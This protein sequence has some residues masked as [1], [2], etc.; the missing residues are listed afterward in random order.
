MKRKLETVKEEEEEEVEK[1]K[2][3]G[4]VKVMPPVK[5]TKSQKSARIERLLESFRMERA[6]KGDFEEFW[7]PSEE[8]VGATSSKAYRDNFNDYIANFEAA[9]AI[10][11]G[12]PQ[13]PF[14][15]EEVAKARQILQEEGATKERE[16]KTKAGRDAPKQKESSPE[17]RTPQMPLS[18]PAPPSPLVPPPISPPEPEVLGI[19]PNV[20]A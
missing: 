10:I 9:D 13:E 18:P 2:K 1:P 17:K 7:K 16:L 11:E 14:T 15:A 6:L 12:A 8:I 20:V 3:K 19:K 4:K 5:E